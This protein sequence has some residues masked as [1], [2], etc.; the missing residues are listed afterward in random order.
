MSSLKARPLTRILLE[1]NMKI[2]NI[3]LVLS[4]LYLTACDETTVKAIKC[5]D[6]SLK[7]ALSLFAKQLGEDIDRS[8]DTDGD[9]LVVSA[10]FACNKSYTAINESALLEYNQ[11]LADFREENGDLACTME[12]SPSYDINN[13][14]AKCAEEAEGVRLCVAHYLFMDETPEEPGAEEGSDQDQPGQPGYPSG[15]N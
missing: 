8:C 3:I 10:D 5:D 4:S 14:E 12:W 9:C 6:K 15:S 1:K 11:L 2:K 7:E 13:Y